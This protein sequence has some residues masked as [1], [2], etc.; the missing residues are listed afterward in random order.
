MTDID[1]CEICTECRAWPS[2]CSCDEIDR[3]K[4]KIRAEFGLDTNHPVMLTEALTAQQCDQCGKIDEL[5]PYG[6][7]NSLICWPCGQLD[8]QD[9]ETGARFLEHLNEGRDI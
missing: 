6:P 7:N 5:R 8:A 3:I 1:G 9:A 4:D 2:M